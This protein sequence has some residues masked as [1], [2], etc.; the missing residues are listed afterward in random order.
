MPATEWL[1]FRLYDNAVPATL[2][3]YRAECERIG[4]GT[5]HLASVD[6]MIARVEEW[7][8]AYPERCETPDIDPGEELLK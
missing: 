7:R 6:K 4:C 5:D 2:R 1:A 3:A 8:A